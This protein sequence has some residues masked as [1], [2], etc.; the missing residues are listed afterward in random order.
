MTYQH[1]LLRSLGHEHL[2]GKDVQLRMQ[3]PPSE[4]RHRPRVIPDL[5]QTLQIRPSSPQLRVR[6]TK[7]EVGHMKDAVPLVVLANCCAVEILHGFR[8][9]VNTGDNLPA[10]SSWFLFPRME[11]GSSPHRDETYASLQSFPPACVLRQNPLKVM[12]IFHQP[13]SGSGLEM[14]SGWPPHEPLQPRAKE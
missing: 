13:F 6:I 10:R 7:I 5:H 2:G 1:D 4:L 12:L 14:Y 3:D 9:S 8:P 11:L